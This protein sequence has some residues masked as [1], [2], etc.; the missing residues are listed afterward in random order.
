MNKKLENKANKYLFAL[1]PIL[2]CVTFSVIFYFYIA[3]EDLI[4]WLGVK[5]AYFLI[6]LLAFIS[7]LSTFSGTSYHLLLI[8]M[9]AG[10][11]NPL[12]LGIMSTF[13]VMSGDSTSY[14][15]GHKSSTFLPERFQPFFQRVHGFVDKHPKMFPMICFVYGAVVPLSND[16]LTITS[17]MMGYSFWRMII[18]LG[19]GNLIYNM[20]LTFLAFRLYGLLHGIGF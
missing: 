12:L 19:L 7:G 3:P 1:I 4:N 17:G 18:P 5:N 13:G 16:F 11:M 6:L 9:A 20:S 14:Y 10:G 15:L 8:T 2:L